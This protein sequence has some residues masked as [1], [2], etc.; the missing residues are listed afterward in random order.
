MNEPHDPNAPNDLYQYVPGTHS[1]RGKFTDRSAE[2]S[3][4]VCVLL[5]RGWFTLGAA[6]LV[7]VGGAMLAAR[8]RT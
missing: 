6:A 8:R 2:T 7:A 4:E 1:A 5:H 3:A